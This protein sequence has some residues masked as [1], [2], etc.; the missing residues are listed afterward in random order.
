MSKNIHWNPKLAEHDIMGNALKRLTEVGE[1]MAAEVKKS[2]PVGTISRPMY[3]RTYKTGKKGKQRGFSQAYW[4]SR[5][6]G[7]L[8]RS[9]R[10]TKSWE[11]IDGNTLSEMSSRNVWVICGDTKAYYGKIIEYG[12]NGNKYQGFFRKAINRSKKR[13]NLILRGV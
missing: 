5:D 9:V 13:A 4:T 10:I 12:T 3:K 2:T 6:A 1:V 8:Q 11:D 7:A